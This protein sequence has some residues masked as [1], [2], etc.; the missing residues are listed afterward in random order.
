M[1]GP[2]SRLVAACAGAVYARVSGP[3]HWATAVVG[4]VVAAGAG[5]GWSSPD[6]DQSRLFRVLQRL[7]PNDPDPFGHHG[8]THWFGWP[9]LAWWGTVA[10]PLLLQWPV[11]LLIVGWASHVAVDALFGKIPLLP[12]GGWRVGLGLKTGGWLERGL[13]WGPLPLLCGWLIIGAPGT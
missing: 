3:D 13:V 7:T 9:V 1:N 10:L 6:M 12:W 11:R 8:T 4:A 2:G 5:H